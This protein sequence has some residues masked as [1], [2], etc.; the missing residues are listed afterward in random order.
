MNEERSAKL[1]LQLTFLQF[2]LYMLV[3]T[4][5]HVRT[6]KEHVDVDTYDFGVAL[7]SKNIK[8]QGL[9]K[10]TEKSLAGF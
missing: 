2:Q 6:N 7:H 10:E 8:S 4:R 3:R 5:A 9:Q 1:S